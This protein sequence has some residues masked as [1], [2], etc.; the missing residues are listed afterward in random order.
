VETVVTTA[1]VD[2]DLLSINTIRG[3]CIDAV[4]RANSGHSFG[5]LMGTGS[6]VQLAMAAREELLAE[7]ID[8]RVVSM[9]C[10]A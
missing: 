7:G 10:W 4:E 1:D 3:L 2:P 9:P 6:E 5:Y 8:A